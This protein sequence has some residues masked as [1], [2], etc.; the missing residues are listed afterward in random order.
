MQTV[1]QWRI[2]F[3]SSNPPRHPKSLTK[4]N[5]ILN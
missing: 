5:P 2:W 1:L 3:Q 4:T